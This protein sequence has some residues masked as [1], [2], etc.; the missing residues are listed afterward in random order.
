MSCAPMN[1]GIHISF[2]NPFWGLHEIMEK[3]LAL[4]LTFSRHSRNSISFPSPTPL[5]SVS[6]LALNPD[7]VFDHDTVSICRGAQSEQDGIS[8]WECGI[9]VDA[10]G[11]Q[12]LPLPQW[13]KQGGCKI[14]KD[15]LP[16][17]SSLPK[18]TPGPASS[19]WVPIGTSYSAGLAPLEPR[20]RV[21]G[22]RL[23]KNDKICVLSLVQ[24]ISWIWSFLSFEL[25]FLTVSLS[26]LSIFPST[27]MYPKPQLPEGMWVR[28]R[29]SGGSLSPA[30]T[31]Y[32]MV[33]QEMPSRAMKNVSLVL[34]YWYNI[35]LFPPFL[36]SMSAT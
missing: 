4:F 12:P 10:A 27:H 11:R 8:H 22:P 17:P 7:E 26:L 28:P 5:S 3:D 31:Y 34:A 19:A 15:I 24:L 13:G 21:V 25:A 6:V 9:Q 30:I 14:L 20:L 35:S 23:G 29:P 1:M 18:L 36:L 2:Q 16:F 32:N 33:A